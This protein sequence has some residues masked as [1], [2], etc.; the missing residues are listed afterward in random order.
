[1]FDRKAAEEDAELKRLNQATFRAKNY[2]ILVDRAR[3][4]GEHDR[5]EEK[6]CFNAASAFRL[7]AAAFRE[8]EPNLDKPST[9]AIN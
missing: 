6:K 2:S 8:G 5:A 1:M 9:S 3:M 7:R 4:S